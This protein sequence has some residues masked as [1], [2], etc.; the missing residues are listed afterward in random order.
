[1]CYY[2][3]YLFHHS[4]NWSFFFE[5]QPGANH[6]PRASV[7]QVNHSVH[8]PSTLWGFAQIPCAS[9]T[10]F[11]S[12]TI[13][14]FSVPSAPT[15]TGITTVFICHILCISYS[16]Y[17]FLL[18]FSIS[19]RAMFLSDGTVVSISLQMEFTGSL[20]TIF[21]IFAVIVQSVLTGMSHMI[22][23]LLSLLCIT[24]SGSCW[25]HLSVVSISWSWQ[26]LHWSWSPRLEYV[27]Q[28]LSIFRG[29][30][31]S[32][33]LKLWHCYFPFELSSILGYWNFVFR[34][35]MFQHLLWILPPVCL[36]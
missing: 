31:I 16:R 19:F 25:Y 10:F 4:L 23:M 3:Y 24:V 32:S 35:F 17:L 12:S 26:I 13:L 5:H 36:R 15:T 30:F 11:T 7:T 33:V 28:G 9:D 6:A 22:V 1:M 29:Q 8:T 18:F 2:C 27:F 34:S 21:G 20:N 14:L